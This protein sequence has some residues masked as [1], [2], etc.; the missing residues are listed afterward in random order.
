MLLVDDDHYATWNVVRHPLD[1][2][3]LGLPKA[4]ALKAEIRFSSPATCVN[5]LKLRLGDT[6]LQDGSGVTRAME[7][8]LRTL[9]SFDLIIDAT[10]DIGASYFLNRFSLGT[11]VPFMVVTV[12]EGGWG[13][14]VVRSIPGDTGCFECYEWNRER[15]PPSQSEHAQP[16]FTRG[17]GFPTFAGSGFDA[18]SL[19]ADAARIAV[20]TLLRGAAS[21]AP[22][23]EYDVLV[24]HNCGLEGEARYPRY[25]TAHLE[26]DRRCAW[27]SKA[28][29]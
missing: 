12:T 15:L 8:F 14:E 26:I 13:G 21:G 20:Q 6:P 24:R 17:C 3:A 1:L 18:V 2:R 19:A 25:E 27:H 28:A 7:E 16:I 22:G 29:S 11:G 4:D 9:S 10:A 5:V 23:A